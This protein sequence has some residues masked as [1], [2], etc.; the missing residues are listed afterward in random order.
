MALLKVYAAPGTAVVV[1]AGGFPGSPRLDAIT[2]DPVKTEGG[3]PSRV[4]ELRFGEPGRIRLRIVDAKG[5]DV[6]FEPSHVH[7]Y[8]GVIESN[9]DGTFILPALNQFAASISVPGFATRMVIFDPPHARPREETVRLI[10]DQSVTVTGRLISEGGSTVRDSTVVAIDV[11]RSVGEPEEDDWGGDSTTLDEGRFELEG[12]LR[13]AATLRVLD[14]KD[15]AVV[16]YR[17]FVVTAD[18][19]LGDVFVPR[20]QP[21]GGR[22]V[23]SAGAPIPGAAIHVEDGGKREL[24]ATTTRPDGTFD[25]VLAPGLPLRLTVSRRGYVE[26]VVETTSGAEQAQ[27]V[28]ERK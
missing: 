21:F 3:V 25:V 23:D 13:G 12:F 8:S 7:L 24:S 17:E 4:V 10:R 14:P 19:D 9:A 1:A 27:I 15:L 22:V 5:H 16:V 11:D 20:R 6:A 26:R 2:P 18:T 28:L